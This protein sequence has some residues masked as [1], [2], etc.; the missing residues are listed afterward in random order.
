M[1]HDLTI[2]EIR[3]EGRDA[4]AVSF[5]LPE[6]LKADFAFLP[7]Q[8]LTLRSE[9]AGEDVRRSYSIASAPGAPLTVG[10][11][12]VEG[13][14]FSTAAQ[15]WKPGDTVQVMPPEG[16]FTYHGQGRIV[17]VAAGSGI[18]PMV[19]I[20]SEALEQGGE[21]ALI[22]GNRDSGSIMFLD[23][24]EALK[25][26]YL[27]RFTL[28]HVLSREPQ[29]VALLN[30]RIDG[31]KVTA[32]ARAGAIDLAGTDGVFLCGPGEM[33]EN[34]TGALDGMVS[35]DK[36]HHE[37]FYTEVGPRP[38]RSAKAMA[39]AEAGVTVDV[40]L[41]GA[42]R[43]FQVEAE[44]EDVVAAAARQGLEL[45][46]SCKGGMCCTC[47]CKVVEGD[48]EMAVNFSLEPWELEAGFTLA[49]QAR[50]TSEKLVLDFDAA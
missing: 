16:R 24:L 49:C 43:S 44:D 3:P 28:I 30:G 9:I 45:P 14:C 11:K 27:D 31:E 42:R 5:D 40:I 13:G 26:R 19:S 18:T 36:I 10:I 29:D 41:D 22:Y 34:V 39:A 35:A 46:F 15:D 17:L 1:F 4:I 48:A 25:D 2:S 33:I 8:Y 38:E 50:P 21:V 47:R 12:R 37:L 20:A 23:A 6:A 32:L 7:G